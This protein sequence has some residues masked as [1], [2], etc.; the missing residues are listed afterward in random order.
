MKSILKFIGVVQSSLKNLEDCPLQESE[1]APQ[2][3]LNVFPEFAEGIQNIKAGAEIMLLL[4]FHKA[5]R[6]VLKCVTR[7]NY[8][9]PKIG[10]FSTRSPDRPNPIGVHFVKVISVNDDVITVSALEA[11]DETPIIDIKPVLK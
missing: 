4:W 9:S 11:L 3:V 10:V 1:D 5:D 8:N 2:A 7:N 6:S